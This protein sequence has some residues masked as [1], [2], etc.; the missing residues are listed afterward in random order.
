MPG[1]RHPPGADIQRI[2]QD[3]RDRYHD[4]FPILK[5][6]LQNADDAGA[7]QNGHPATQWVFAFS[8]QGLP[9]SKHSLLNGAGIA[10]LNDG[11]FTPADANS[12]TSLGLSNKAA[13]AGAAGKFGLGLKS[14][15]HWSEAFFYFSPHLFEGDPSIQ[16]PGYDLLN[17]WS[18]RDANTGRHREWDEEWQRTHEEDLMAF[19]CLVPTVLH[20]DRWFGLWI[21]LRKEQHTKDARGAVQPIEAR[22]PS[23]QLD[24]LF[25]CDW[26]CRLAE[27]MPL[28]RRVRVL[29]VCKYS[30]TGWENVVE[31]KVS[32]KAQRITL[33]C[34]DDSPKTSGTRLLKGEIDSGGPIV[35]FAGAE[36]YASSNSLEAL[37]LNAAWPSQATL[38]PDGADLQV[39]EKAEAHGATLFTRQNGNA[40]QSARI[41]HAVFL[42]LGEPEPLRCDGAWRY[43][44][45]L[46]GFFF[47]DSGR[48]HIQDDGD[49]PPDILPENAATERDVIRLWNRILMREVVAPLV[50]PSLELFVREEKIPPAE[51]GSLVG[52]LQRSKVLARL[53]KW[54]CRKMRFI[55]RL[56][57]SGSD[58]VL[59]SSPKADGALPTWLELPA[60]LFPEANLFGLLPGLA[61]LAE[62]ATISLKGKACLADH[63]PRRLDDEES[64]QLIA[65]VFESVFLEPLKL[66]YLLKLIPEDAAKRTPDSPLA[67]GLIAL[68]RKLVGERSP[69]DG[70][71]RNLWRKF[72]QRLPSKTLIRLPFDS[73]NFVPD[74]ARI[75]ADARLSAVLVCNELSERAGEGTLDWRELLPLLHRL[76][77]LTLS[78]DQAIQQRSE[79]AVLLLNSCPTRPNDWADIISGLSLFYARYPR[80]QVCAATL[81][82]LRSAGRECR[83]F[84]GGE[85]WAADLAKAAPEAKPLLIQRNVASLL[86]DALPECDAIPC[87]NVLRRQTRL[88][89]DFCNRRPLFD[90][91]LSQTHRLGQEGW[92]ALRCLIHGQVSRWDDKEL[93][94]RKGSDHEV[95]MVLAKRALDSAQQAWRLVPIPIGLQLALNDEQEKRLSLAAASGPQVE[96]LVSQVGPDRVECADLAAEDCEVLLLQLNQPKVLRGLN[97][98]DTVTGERV[99]IGHLT[100]VDDDSFKDLPPEFGKVVT[101]LRDRAGYARFGTADGGNNLVNKLS[102]AAVI[103]VALDQPRP[104]EWWQVILAAIG[105]RDPRW[106]E[107]RGRVLGTEWLPLAGG[108]A[109]RPMDLLSI[110]GADAEVNQLPPEVLKGC[111]PIQRLASEVLHHPRFDAFKSSALPKPSEALV[112]LAT[113]LKPH[114]SW[115]TGLSGEWSAEQTAAWVRVLGG[116]PPTALPVAR[117]IKGLHAEAVLK[118]FLPQF[119]QS[120]GGRLTEAAYASILNCSAMVHSAEDSE[121]QG[122]VESVFHRYLAAVDASGLNFARQVLKI[123]GARLLSASGKWKPASQLASPMEGISAD[124]RIDEACAQAMPELVAACKQ[125]EVRVGKA[126][127]AENADTWRAMANKVRRYFDQWRPQLP[128]P[129][130]I[131]AFLSLFTALE[132]MQRLAQDFYQSH[133]LS[134]VEQWFDQ[135]YPGVRTQLAQ[136]LQRPIPHIEIHEEK[137]IFVLSIVGTGFE[138]HRDEHPTTLLVGG[139][140]CLT[141]GPAILVNGVLQPGPNRRVLRL[142]PVNPRALSVPDALRLL[143]TAT[144]QVIQRTI[145]KR[146]DLSALFDQLSKASQIE[147]QVAQSLVVESALGLLRQIGGESHL[148]IKK[149][150]RQ[151]DEAR[152]EEAAAE[153]LGLREQQQ[154]QQKRRAAQR[155]I[156]DM[157]ERDADVHRALLTEVRKRLGQYQYDVSSIP[158]ELWQNADDALM[159]LEQLTNDTASA[160]AAGFFAGVAGNHLEFAHLGRLINEFRIPGGPSREEL[161]FSRDLEKMVVQSISEKSELQSRSGCTLTGKFGLGFKSVFLAT[162][163]PEILSGS[164]DFVI[165]GGIYPVRLQQPGREC[166]LSTLKRW[167]P[168]EWRRGTIIRLPNAIPDT[169]QKPTLMDLFHRLAPLLVVFSHRLKRI[170]FH[171]QGLEDYDI[172]WHPR[173]VMDGVDFGR[174]EEFGNSANA[175][176]LSRS[177]AR[178]RDR[179]QFLLGMNGDGFVPLAEDVP[180][181]WVTAPTRMTSGYGFAVNGPFEP[182]VGRV[183]LALK[184]EKNEQLAVEAAALI[185]DRLQALWRLAS[186]DW[187]TVRGALGLTDGTSQYELWASLWQVVGDHFV[188]K[189]R[190]D[191]VGPAAELS[192][193]M[194]WELNSGAMR[195]FY[196]VCAAL[197]TGLWEQHRTLTCLQDLR[198]S[199]SGVLDRE[200]AFA[201][202]ASWPQFKERVRAGS[203]SSDAR[204]MSTLQGLGMVVTNAE[205]LHLTTVVEWEVGPDGHADAERAARLGQL[206][207]PSFLKSLKDGKPEAP[208]YRDEREHKAIAELLERTEFQAQD[209]SW[210]R[211][212]KLVV[213]VPSQSID[214]DETLRAAFAPRESLLHSSYAG[215]AL[216]FFL[217][218]RSGLQTGTE[219]LVEWA[220]EASAET[221]Q[222][223]VL[224]YLLQGTLKDSL[225]EALR[226]RRDD[227]RWLWRLA[228]YSWFE[229]AF[230]ADE[231]HQIRAY[232]LRLY[233]EELRSGSMQPLLAPP[234]LQPLPRRVCSVSELW[235]WW[236]DE[237]M[238]MD[239][240]TLEGEAN[241]SLFHGGAIPDGVERKSE[242]KRLLQLPSG[243]AGKALWYR[244]FGYACLIS[245]G[246]TMTE[247]RRF[248]QE[249]LDPEHFWERTAVGEFTEETREIFEHAVTAE[250]SNLNAGREQA[251]FWRRVFYDLRKVHRMIVN[252]FPAVLLE[253]VAQGRGGELPQFLRTG[254]LHGLQQPRWIGTFGQSADTPLGFIVRELVRLEV[255]TA[256][257]VRPY[258]FYTCRPVIR[259]LLKLGWLN[260]EDSWFTGKE[261]QAKLAEDPVHGPKLAPY[262]DIPLLHMGIKYRG[263]RLPAFLQLR[264]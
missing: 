181:F 30:G 86:K 27:T 97:I 36:C 8:E 179:L 54:I 82:Q 32:E 242:L 170:R 84:S 60:P 78:T 215:S 15:F 225:A 154:A 253:L 227:Q 155:Q 204:V 71:L 37:Q 223:A 144:E 202:V 130:P 214:K 162:S 81:D 34:G 66:D 79:L 122:H 135:T 178:G 11:D 145:G 143:R 61:K 189:C 262:Y 3:L 103:E 22:F 17:P 238:P 110:P 168:D 2:R 94:F 90:R 190:R 64:G 40:Q 123:D 100:Y 126:F 188:R 222:V 205:P 7:T 165:H 254:H 98:H 113:L 63:G 117:L 245:A 197:P 192:R 219:R 59:Q 216:D 29:R 248:W 252:D 85:A 138:A 142:L 21:P 198:Y 18:S 99:R 206:I 41:H 151:W 183:Q 232:V 236:T 224:R 55:S 173:Q 106:P 102:W 167:V 129:E 200:D 153:L 120:I 141:R 260:D 186:K 52:A 196:Q 180:V 50:L 208:T 38:G 201:V 132:P 95:F 230:T 182:D 150:L 239:D 46:H 96:T 9:G 76:G 256:E 23:A 83:L 158:F 42:P 264:P 35:S 65:G 172:H 233:D 51:V 53:M 149:A 25:G 119:L 228:E 137:T 176:V 247:L 74:M 56:T 12:L 221:P 89:E 124:D 69:E 229:K 16:S 169:V 139:D 62:L 147:V 159:E 4:G 87:V 13:Q 127:D 128:S 263:D 166:L 193:Q 80:A 177:S 146:V 28:L 240:Y 164:V 234:I 231:R 33:G 109:A 255:V 134:E 235:S 44:L 237:R 250:F 207:T 191:D 43:N 199:A 152:R 45:Y 58:W 213:A 108:S 226:Q 212:G 111:V 194:L 171:S 184:S 161:G 251:Y 104:S 10:V 174:L 140:P 131:G 261:W 115:S 105:R 92:A 133:S 20:S 217:A 1:F 19:R 70:E 91:L 57:P 241:W 24:E 187:Q 75:C 125:S 195:Q 73:T 210:H 47:V 68:A 156:R 26:Q 257:A 203:I 5:E 31:I 148:G 243:P 112:T 220:L 211:P 185:S 244:L 175:L 116:A 48:R 163:A 88:S 93:M 246:R 136:A 107:L 160:R 14:V 67:G 209:G 49:L 39:R 6:L 114:A 259:A 249:R 72:F 77:G 218:A 121:R 101:R 118:D 157:L 258:A